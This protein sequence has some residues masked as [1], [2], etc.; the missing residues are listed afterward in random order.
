MTSGA[1]PGPPK[2]ATTNT[3]IGELVQTACIWEVTARKVGNVHRYADFHDT[4]YLDFILSA[5]AIAP[6]F[7]SPDVAAVGSTIHRCVAATRRA[8]GRNTN[9]GM[10]LLF[11]PLA[12]VPIGKPLREGVCEVL[13]RL[14]ID[15]ARHAY[16]GI[17]LAIPGGLGQ[18]AS[19]DVRE[20]PTV[21]LFEAMSLAADRDRIARQYA[22]GFADV[23]DFGLLAF[24]EGLSR[25]GCI[26]AAIVHSQLRW[27]AAYP[28]SLIARKNGVAVAEVVRGMAEEVLKRGGLETAEGRAAG[29]ELDR[30]LRR[31]GNKL[32]PGATA[33]LIAACL[34]AALR[35]NEGM[36]ATPFEWPR[37]D[38]LQWQASDLRS[39]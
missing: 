22:T 35:E 6:H 30:L 19:E 38:W 11:A 27:L 8:I 9:L 21:T 17:R 14:T 1:S 20:E 24:Q 16:E 31:D 18:A 23:F 26:E 25:F 33:D 10:I 2:R 37:K 4:T 13:A 34:L 5:A 28:D 29:T 3:T 39:G 12:A 7:D 36:R 15:D 32:N